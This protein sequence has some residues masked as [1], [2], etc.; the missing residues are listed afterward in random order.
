VLEALLGMNGFMRSRWTSYAVVLTAA[1]ACYAALGA[2][3]RAIP[4]Y[5]P[6]TL[7]VGAVGVG[8]AV[9]APAITGAVARPLGGRWADR[10]GAR[11]VVVL[12]ALLMSVAVL[13]AFVSSYPT[14]LISRLA[15]GCG[16]AAMMSAAVLW[17]LRIAGPEHR[18][19]SL[20]HI[21]LANY[22]GLTIG[23]LLVSALSADQHIGRLGLLAIFLPLLGAGAALLV[24][25][26]SSRQAADPEQASIAAMVR[27]TGRPGVGLLL[28]N[29]GY[30][31]VLS[32]GAIVVADHGLRAA[33]LIVPVFGAGVIVSRIAL[34]SLTDRIGPRVVLVAAALTEAAG[35]GCSRSP[36]SRVSPS[37]RS[38]CCR[39]G[40]ASPYRRWVS[41]RSPACPTRSRA[42][43]PGRS[44]PGSTE[45][46]GSAAR[47]SASWRDSSHR[48][49][50]SSRLRLRS[51][52]SCRSSSW[53]G[54]PQLTR[55]IGRSAQLLRRRP[56]S[57]SLLAGRREHVQP[58]TGADA[59]LPLVHQPGVFERLHP[60]EHGGHQRPGADAAPVGR[61][62]P[63]DDLHRRR[64]GLSLALGAVRPE[65]VDQ[66]GPEIPGRQSDEPVDF[67]LCR[68]I[69]CGSVRGLLRVAFEQRH[70]DPPTHS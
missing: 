25:D 38:W 36:A 9:G 48:R 14:L 41:W 5:V 19:R 15:V 42:R 55:E 47:W 46:S 2:V 64:S 1:V 52:R 35:W 58:R 33:G 16:E 69:L 54:R 24:H 18:G 34:G 23:P 68:R 31:A 28:V 32:F 53:A 49:P 39:S 21:G 8:L 45:A 10:F 59:G 13:P 4:S 22:G 60:G 40:R 70:R 26:S 43:P 7:G 29:I 63:L 11:R 62:Q 51:P 50:R 66:L 37:S 61:H 65:S 30:V 17:L 44:S 67:R 27:R 20:G 3:L 57:Q 56:V 12:G 6:D